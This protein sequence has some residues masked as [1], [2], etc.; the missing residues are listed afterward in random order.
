MHRAEEIN[1]SEREYIPRQYHTPSHGP[2]CRY[3]AFRP[4]YRAYTS[5]Q[6]TPN[7]SSE[8][9]KTCVRTFRAVVRH[10]PA[11]RLERVN[12]TIRRG[13]AQAAADVAADARRGAVH[14]DKRR[15]ATRAAA[16]SVV[17]VPGIRRTAPEGVRALEREHGLRDVGLDV[18]DGARGEQEVNELSGRVLMR[19]NAR[20]GSGR[21]GTATYVG[22]RLRGLVSPLREAH[23]RVVALDIDLWS[24]EGRL[25][26]R[27]KSTYTG[28]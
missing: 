6:H 7:L 27:L 13:D 17:R 12:T 2:G 18:E 21:G 25:R 22:V 16:A 9:R 3:D 1:L 23:G 20:V 5:V 28:L 8:G 14:G 15:L 10:A 24:S 19:V 26:S 4:R 11:R